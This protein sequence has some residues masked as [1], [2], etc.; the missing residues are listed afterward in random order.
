MPKNFDA[1]KIVL[2]FV[3]SNFYISRKTRTLTVIPLGHYVF[4]KSTY[5]EVLL[6]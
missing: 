4:Y 6:F 5:L 1:C 3:S 2:P